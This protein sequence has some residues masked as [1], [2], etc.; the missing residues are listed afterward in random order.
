MPEKV[1]KQT[2]RR[3]LSAIFDDL[4]DRA[5]AV[6]KKYNPCKVENGTCMAG[7][8]IETGLCCTGCRHLGPNGCTTKSLIC[9]MWLCYVGREDRSDYRDES[10]RAYFEEMKPIMREAE[11]YQLTSPRCSKAVAINSVLRCARPI[12]WRQIRYKNDVYYRPEQNYSDEYI[13]EAK[14]HYERVT[15]IRLPGNVTREGVEVL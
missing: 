3:Q 11:K 5:S 12:T 15:G 14:I 7:R 4:Y 1:A 6:V 10:I 8:K 9:R 2:A 13:R